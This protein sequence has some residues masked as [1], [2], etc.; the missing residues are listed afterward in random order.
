MPRF[1]EVKR[2]LLELLKTNGA[3]LYFIPA[4]SPELNRIEM[5]G[6]EKLLDFIFHAADKIEQW[7]EKVSNQ[8]GKEYMFLFNNL[9]I[10]DL[11]VQISNERARGTCRA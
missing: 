7:V 2:W 8:F 3:N 9:Q 10:A 6:T 5:V 4:Y 1:I 11:Q